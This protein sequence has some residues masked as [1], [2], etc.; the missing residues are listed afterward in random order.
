MGQVHVRVTLTNYRE[1]LLAHL[2]Q[3]PVDQVHHY[4]TEALVDTSAM[5][6]VI[7]PAVADRLGLLRLRRTAARYV[8][9]QVAEVDVSEVF[10]IEVMGRQAHEDAMI[11]G[12]HVLLGVTVLER[13]DLMVDGH[14]QQL[15]PYEGTWDQPVFRV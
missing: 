15:V 11:I 4:E 9:D 10:T 8:N 7:P 6:C 3:L 13:L 12:T 5:Q 14:R 1:A 2:G